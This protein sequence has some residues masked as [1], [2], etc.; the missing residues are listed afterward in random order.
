MDQVEVFFANDSHEKIESGSVDVSKISLF[1]MAVLLRTSEGRNYE[2]NVSMFCEDIM[3]H[4]KT[5]VKGIDDWVSLVIGCV[6]ATC[7]GKMDIPIV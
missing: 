4:E 3:T 6:R 5:Q 2:G 7:H 1:K